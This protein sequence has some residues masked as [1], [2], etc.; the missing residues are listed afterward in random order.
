MEKLKSDQQKEIINNIVSNLSHEHPDL[1]YSDSNHIAYLIHQKIQEK[2]LNKSQFDLV[3]DL[4]QDD[5]HI[6]MSFK[7]NCC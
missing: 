2:S 1:Y 5:I 4:S 6:M 3:K 7:T